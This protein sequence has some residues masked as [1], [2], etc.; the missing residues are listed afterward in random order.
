[1]A[2]SEKDAMRALVLRGGPWS[3]QER[4]AILSYCEQDVAALTRLLPPMLHHIDLPRALLRGR[5]MAAA[6]AMEHN[7]VPVDVRLLGQLREKWSDI[8]SIDRRY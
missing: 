2:A 1:M 7:G 6:A 4:E 5:Y 8:R 3:E